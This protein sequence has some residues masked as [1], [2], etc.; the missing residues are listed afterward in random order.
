MAQQIKKKYLSSEVISYFD[1]QIDAVEVSATA[2]EAA[3]IA[4]DASTLS[5]ANSYTDGEI[6]ALGQAL[7]GRVDTEIADRIAG[8]VSTLASANSYTDAQ[9]V[10]A[11]GDISAAEAAIAQ[12]ILDRQAA[13]S[14][15]QSAREAADLVID[16]KIETEKARIDAILLASDADKDS[17]A[18]IVSLIN[19]VDTENDSAF[20]GYVLSN[21]AALAQEISDRQSGDASTLQ[22]AK[23]YTDAQIAAIPAV[24][25]SNYY[26]KS[27]VDAK[28]SALASDI[29]DLDVYAQDIRSDVDSLEVYAQDIR[30]DVDAHETELA[31]HDS[32]LDAL[33]AQVDGPAFSN[34]SVIVGEELS[35]I[36][37]DREYIKLMSCAVGRM[38]IHEGEDFTVSVV[39]GKTRLTWIGSLLNPS[40]EE[41]IET[42]DKVFFVGAY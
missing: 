39:G 1:D 4:G 12:E 11:Q 2:E 27:E 7:D 10:S 22:S 3:R 24:D 5:S 26:T 23:D 37:L 16:G 13:D 19:S 32:R 29:S 9:I 31:S 17:F 30:S 36:D 8:D 42:G 14:A 35:Y 40:G 38:A 34:G 6:D 25:L 28:E 20:A 41:K 33:E 15:E 18:E 21:N